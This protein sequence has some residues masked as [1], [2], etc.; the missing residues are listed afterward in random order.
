MSMQK[1]RKDGLQVT[2][3]VINIFYCKTYYLFN[4][5]I[6]HSPSYNLFRYNAP[7][8]INL[9]GSKLYEDIGT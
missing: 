9:T 2:I 1:T 3:I 4:E 8:P 7:W 6:I 5:I